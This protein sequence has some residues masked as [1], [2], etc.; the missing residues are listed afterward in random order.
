MPGSPTGKMPVLSRL[1]LCHYANEWVPTQSEAPGKIFR[2]ADADSRIGHDFHLVFRPN[3]KAVPRVSAKVDLMMT[4]RDVERLRQL[5]GTGTEPP[6]V[7]NSAPLPHQSQ[8]AL[9]LDRANE[10]EAIARAAF[11]EDVEHPVHAVIEINVGRACFVA[12]DKGARARPRECMTGFVPFH[13]IG[14]HFDHNAP[15]F[16]PHQLSADQFARAN[17]RVSFEEGI[18]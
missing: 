5:A 12:F 8:T 13:Q 4:F 16:L 11:D 7:F 2:P 9:R 1:R 15:A 6:N 17:Q 14:F 3:P 18:R 10:N